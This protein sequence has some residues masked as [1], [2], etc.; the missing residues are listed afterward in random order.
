MRKLAFL[1]FVNVV[2]PFL[3]SA[4]SFASG[5]PAVEVVTEESGAEE[6]TSESPPAPEESPNASTESLPAVEKPSPKKEGI[7]AFGA[8]YS[9]DI[10]PSENDVFVIV[11]HNEAGEEMECRMDASQYQSEPA[12]FSVLPGTYTITDAF[13]EGGNAEI[14][15]QGF[16]LNTR[17]T[18]GA[19][20]Y[21]E[22]TL[23]IG[24][25]EGA[26]MRRMYSNSLAKVNGEV[27]GRAVFREATKAV[28]ISE[29]EEK[30]VEKPAE[31]PAE[32]PTRE[33]KD[34]ARDVKAESEAKVI[35]EKKQPKKT[36][37]LLRGVPILGA[38]AITAIGVFILHKKD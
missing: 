16:A 19:N 35:Y 14:H 11:Y 36:S 13:Y 2:T 17:A 27:V 34:D 15:S 38:A 23:A 4:P 5:T 37:L 30:P 32:K 25:K 18:I 29:P 6:S 3:F 33:T 21:S 28:P 7:L 1:L 26:L 8:L 20:G 12:M 9:S 24:K 10:Q 31:K 22:I